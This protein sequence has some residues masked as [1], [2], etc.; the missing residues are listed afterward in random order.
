MG[1]SAWVLGLALGLVAVHTVS[2][3][4]YTL[5]GSTAGWTN[6][7]NINYTEELAAYTIKVGDTLSKS[8]DVKNLPQASASRVVP[9]CRR[10]NAKAAGA[11]S[12]LSTDDGLIFD[13]GMR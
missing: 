12:C 13:T 4:N 6:T 11:D 1:S 3:T 7:A 10:L 8:E 9:Q 5:G 2:A